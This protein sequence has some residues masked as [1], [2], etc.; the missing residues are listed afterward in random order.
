MLVVLVWMLVVHA[1]RTPEASSTLLKMHRLYM[2]QPPHDTS[3]Y[4]I[5]RVSPNA[6][7]AEIT[8][9]FRQRTRELHPDKSRH[10]SN[11]SEEE[12]Q[13]KLEQVREAYEVLKDDATRLLYH[14]F[15]L[16]D[17][18]MAAFV[19]TGGKTGNAI[20]SPEQ[21]KLLEWMGYS[22]P[23]TTHQQ[24]RELWLLACLQ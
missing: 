3:L 6:T 24:V 18:S 17:T 1:R 14:R 7:V 4:N 22:N 23:R 8:K 13:D 21:T 5:L 9:S 11:V 20:P 19:L 15:G 10:Y 2:M 12:R 16:L